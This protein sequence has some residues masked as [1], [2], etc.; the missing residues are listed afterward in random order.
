MLSIQSKNCRNS[1]SRR[2]RA[3]LALA[4]MFEDSSGRS[5]CNSRAPDRQRM[6]SDRPQ[7]RSSS[8]KPPDSVFPTR[9]LDIGYTAADHSRSDTS[10]LRSKND[11]SDHTTLG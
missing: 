8:E 5:S 6:P 3:I 1:I 9:S 10:V 4:E 11:F 2:E 7:S